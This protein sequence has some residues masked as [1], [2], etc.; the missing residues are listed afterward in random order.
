VSGCN[1]LT[2]LLDSTSYRRITIIIIIIIIIII[3]I[4]IIIIIII[5]IIIISTA[6]VLMIIRIFMCISST[7][8]KLVL[9]V[10]PFIPFSRELPSAASSGLAALLKDLAGSVLPAGLRAGS[11]E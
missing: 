4:I 7:H 8:S 2:L 3:T 11:S 6:I 5:T 1:S 10:I 9:C